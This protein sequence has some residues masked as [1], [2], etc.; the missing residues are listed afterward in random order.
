MKCANKINYHCLI[1]TRSTIHR[2]LSPPTILEQKPI[3]IVFKFM[4][5]QRKFSLSL[6]VKWALKVT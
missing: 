5:H 2:S 1:E 4:K 3:E 6:D